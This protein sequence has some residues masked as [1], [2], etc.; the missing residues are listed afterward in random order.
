[1]SD[2]NFQER[3]RVSIGSAI[4]L[5]LTKGILD[6]K[7]TTAYLLSCRNEKCLANCS[8][9][10]QARDNDGRADMLSRVI[11]P[12]FP[13]EKVIV[14]IERATHEKKIQRVCIQS[15][16]YPEAFGDVMFLVKKIKCKVNVPI[17]VSCKPLNRQNMRKWAEVGVNRVSIALDAASEEVFRKVK[18]QDVGEHYRWK[19]HHEAL[20][21]AVEV[22]G[23]GCVSTHLIVGLGET[24]KELCQ[25]IQW[26]VDSG[27]YPGLFAFTPIPGTALE[28]SLSPLLS[29]YRRAQ[30][31][32]YILTCNKTRF[33][34][35]RFNTS[36]NLRSFGISRE[37]LLEIIETG[38]PFLTSGC[39]GCNRPYY[40]ERPI[41]PLYNYPRQLQPEEIEEAKKI[42][43]F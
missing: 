18:G 37:K 42:L 10:P 8:F 7:P 33:E 38:K 32:H 15:L 29:S 27:V 16:N 20:M 35:M 40:N 2:M 14:K 34:N 36:G 11:W 3:I 41:G 24:E 23:K 30:V 5:G 4:A 26:C 21:E 31:A 12:M 17:S 9:C 28:S 1:M 43:G 19:K 22:F 25:K 39:P 6:V 13:S